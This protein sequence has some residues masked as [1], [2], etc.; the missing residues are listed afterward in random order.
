M[1]FADFKFTKSYM[2]RKFINRVHPPLPSSFALSLLLVWPVSHSCPL[3]FVSVL[4][5]VWSCL[6]ILT[7][8]VLYFNNWFF[9]MNHA[10][11]SLSCLWRCSPSLQ[12]IN[13]FLGMLTTSFNKNIL[14]LI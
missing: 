5:S 11:W 10:L 3:L 8:N 7:G 4:C 2:C 6:G 12:S 14:F 9:L 1:T 13:M